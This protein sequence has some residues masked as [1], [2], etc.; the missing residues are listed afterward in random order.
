MH[1][2]TR[3]APCAPPA[4]CCCT[5]GG[6]CTEGGGIDTQ[7]G[8]FGL[9]SNQASTCNPLEQ[10]AP[11]VYFEQCPPE[12]C[13]G[14]LAVDQSDGIAPGSEGTAEGG[15]GAPTRL[16]VGA[17]GWAPACEGQAVGQCNREMFRTGMLCGECQEGY[18]QT[19]GG[20][21]CVP[22]AECGPAEWTMPVLGALAVVGYVIVMSSITPTAGVN[23]A[24]IVSSAVYFYQVLGAVRLDGGTAAAA[25]KFESFLK[26]S[27]A[28][29]FAEYSCP[30]V[31]L[32]T[33]G[34]MKLALGRSL[35]VLLA[36][37]LTLFTLER[38]NISCDIRHSCCCGVLLCKKYLQ[39]ST[40]LLQCNG[41]LVNKSLTFQRGHSGSGLLEK[42]APLPCRN[43]IKK[44]L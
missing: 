20:V 31:E 6:N 1:L 33:L 23:A 30:L 28:T 22:H 14:A 4:R 44:I 17:P 3:A 42:F 40:Y 2:L 21:K 12:Y 26:L 24:R 18:S 43:N 8:F 32:T 27:S 38:R 7:P 29:V 16:K 35:G 11:C 15:E 36:S 9:V 25:T 37:L 41:C 10:L 13:C 39:F 34:S 5:D 19:L